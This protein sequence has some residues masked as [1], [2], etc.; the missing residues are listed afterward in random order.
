LVEICGCGTSNAR[1]DGEVTFHCTVD[2]RVG[3]P[4][5]LVVQGSNVV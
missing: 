2:G 5:F 1:A 3:A 4:N